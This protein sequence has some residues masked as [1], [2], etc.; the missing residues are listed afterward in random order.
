MNKIERTVFYIEAILSLL[1]LAGGVVQ[2]DFEY[3][4]AALLLFQTSIQMFIFKKVLEIGEFY[5]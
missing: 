3:V 4:I 2:N 1:I 5:E